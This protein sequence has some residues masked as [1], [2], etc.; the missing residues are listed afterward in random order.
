M[1]C[2][3]STQEDRRLLYFSL[4]AP[5]HIEVTVRA[6]SLYYVLYIHPSLYDCMCG[7]VRLNV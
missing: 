2:W 4:L 6:H 1:S 7:F 3:G 5:Y